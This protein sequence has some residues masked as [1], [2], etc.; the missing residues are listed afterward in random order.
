[1]ELWQRQLAELRN[2]DSQIEQKHAYLAHY[3][4][5][6]LEAT[7]HHNLCVRLRIYR[8]AFSVER[9]ALSV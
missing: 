2:A 5:T 9:S 1:M 6:N 3:E 4:A 7:P 8:L